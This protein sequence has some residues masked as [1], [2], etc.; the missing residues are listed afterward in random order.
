MKKIN[1]LFSILVLFFLT[2]CKSSYSQ[3][4]TDSLYILDEIAVINTNDEG[5]I[6][7]I[8]NIHHKEKK[9]KESDGYMFTIPNQVGFDEYLMLKE[10]GTPVDIDKIFY[11][12]KDSLSNKTFNETH[13][14]FSYSKNIYLIC[15][16]KDKYIQ[17]PLNYKGTQKNLNIIDLRN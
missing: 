16:I 2:S 10:I 12:T 8:L 17:Y 1:T 14:I 3:N 7:Y 5:H 15:K 13:N 6:N 11:E 9:N 4:Y